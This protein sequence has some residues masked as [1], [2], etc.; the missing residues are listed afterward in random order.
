MY[1]PVEQ[2]RLN[3]IRRG[4][5]KPYQDLIQQV[6]EEEPSNPGSGDSPRAS[7]TLLNS[8]SGSPA[9]ALQQVADWLAI[10][11]VKEKPSFCITIT[12]NPNWPEIK[13]PLGPGQSVSDIPVVVCHAQLENAIARMEFKFGHIMDVFRVIEFQKTSTASSSYCFE[14]L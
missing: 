14:G 4:R 7:I 11:R 2:K 12:A 13:S 9:W 3:Y 10:C 1:S 8:V 6:Q 5:D